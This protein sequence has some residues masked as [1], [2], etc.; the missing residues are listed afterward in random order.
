[1]A[2]QT[3]KIAEAG[4][5]ND[6]ASKL[7]SKQLTGLGVIGVGLGLGF[8]VVR[9]LFGKKS[10]KEVQMEPVNLN[11]LVEP[12]LDTDLYLAVTKEKTAVVATGLT[13]RDAMNNAAKE[14]CD[15][16]VIMRAPSREIMESSLH[17]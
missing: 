7:G 2:L 11:A 13:I 16:P 9:K 10:S 1:M 8:F 4:S 5:V 12:Y 14:G 3:Q 6:P 15:E 17:L